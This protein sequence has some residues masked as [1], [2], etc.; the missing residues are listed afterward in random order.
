MGT[1][2]NDQSDVDSKKDQT[3]SGSAI[4]LLGTIADTTWRMFIPTIGLALIG[5]FFD[6]Q[7][8]TKPWLMLVCAIIGA[9][10]AAF[11]VKRQLTKGTK[12]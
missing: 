1:T 4:Y 2:R 10:V 3:A 8:D 7:Y 5:D 6:R 12:T 11:L 9:G